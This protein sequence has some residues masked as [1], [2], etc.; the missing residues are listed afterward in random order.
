MNL[1]DLM[2]K[3]IY[4]DN[5]NITALE[6][7]LKSDLYLNLLHHSIV[8]SHLGSRHIFLSVLINLYYTFIPNANIN[9]ATLF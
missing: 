9:R 7:F 6:A 8:K 4:V 3:L 5:R 1:K 2:A